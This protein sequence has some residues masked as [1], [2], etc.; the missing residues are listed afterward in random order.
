MLKG[1]YIEKV[2]NGEKKATIRKGVYKP[3]YDEVIIHAGGRPIAKAKIT[4][5]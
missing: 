4:R 5:V 1:E 3:K 2:L